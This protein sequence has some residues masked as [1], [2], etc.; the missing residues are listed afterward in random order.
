MDDFL[1]DDIDALIDEAE[2]VQAAGEAFEEEL[3]P[4]DFGE[5][6]GGNLGQATLTGSK[7]KPSSESQV[8]QDNGELKQVNQKK[9]KSNDQTLLQDSE[10]QVNSE[11]AKG[12]NEDVM[13][14]DT[15]SKEESKEDGI[16]R[17]RQAP[18]LRSIDVVGDC[19]PI[20][21][22]N[23]ERVY[24]KVDYDFDDD[25]HIMETVRAQKKVRGAN[26]FKIKIE[27][28]LKRVEEKQLQAIIRAN[29]LNDHSVNDADDEIRPTFEEL[30][31][32]K[33]KPKGFT[34][35]MSDERTNREVLQ[36]LKAWD[37]C[38]YGDSTAPARL[39]HQWQQETRDANGRRFKYQKKHSGK[40]ANN[41]NVAGNSGK[42][43]R[44]DLK[45]SD[46]PL[47]KII[48]LTGPP[49]IGKTTLAHIAARHCGYRVV[50]VNASDE[51]TST[52]LKR[53]IQDAI[54]MQSLMG[55]R[56]PNCV[57]LDEIDGLIGG[58]EGRATVD[59][60]VQIATG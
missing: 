22:P 47:H 30:W 6:E 31:V 39:L 57:V 19:M 52:S 18:A 25:D 20:T 2:A 9:L 16:S 13:D 14:D 17:Q 32:D 35:L 40:T 44:K 5:E 27:E 37:P 3:P 56:R 55:E 7:R 8:L 48:L 42:D 45:L 36:W 10:M 15:P 24:V 38:V 4:D 34:D 59:D 60:L 33:Y 1:D 49:G 54:Q 51:R 53:R 46:R 50:E 21:A 26:V 28:T 41:Y 43:L 23:G 58:A 12:P 29:E 11:D